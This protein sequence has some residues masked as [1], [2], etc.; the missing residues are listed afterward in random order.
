M[1][2]LALLLLPLA[3]DPAPTDAELAR[4]AAIMLSFHESQPRDAHEERAQTLAAAGYY[5]G[6]L[7]ASVA[8]SLKDT[9]AGSQYRTAVRNLF[10]REYNKL[11][12]LDEEARGRIA[13]TC[14][15]DYQAAMPL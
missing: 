6:R 3:A 2:L 13:R 7:E 4:C 11:A 15:E 9:I 8:G 14:F 10:E 12:G 5:V 1:R